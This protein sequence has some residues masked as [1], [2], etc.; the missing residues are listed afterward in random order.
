MDHFPKPTAYNRR[1]I[2]GPHFTYKILRKAHIDMT[3]DIK[4]KLLIHVDDKL[5]VISRTLKHG[6]TKPFA[7]LW[8][9]HAIAL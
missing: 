2:Q 5:L 9:F 4:Y 6:V 3:D 7:A 1:K 8:R